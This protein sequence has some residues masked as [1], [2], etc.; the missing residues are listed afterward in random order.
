MKKIIGAKPTG[1][2]LNADKTE[3]KKIKNKRNVVTINVDEKAIQ[4]ELKNMILGLVSEIKEIKE[5]VNDIE[6]TIKNY[7]MYR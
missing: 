7:G 5:K 3:R 4:D 6:K 2:Y 1:D